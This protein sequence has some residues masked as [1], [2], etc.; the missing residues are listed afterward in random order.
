VPSPITDLTQKTEKAASVAAYFIPII[1]SRTKWWHW[2]IGFILIC[3]LSFGGMFSLILASQKLLPTNSVTIYLDLLL[4][5]LP[6]FISIPLIYKFWHRRPIKALMTSAKTFRW[7][8]M[9]RAGFVL[10]AFFSVAS[11]LESIILPHEY[12]GLKIQP[13]AKK[14][15]PLLLITLIFVPFQAASEE[16]L[17]RGYL[18]QALVKYLHS[19]WIV[20]ALTSAGFAAL[21]IANPEAQGQMW[22]YLASIFTFGM[23]MCV[24]LFFEGGI[25]SAIGAHI[26]N[27]IFVFGFLG[28]EDPH[29]PNTAWMTLGAPKIGWGDFAIDFIMIGLVTALIIWANR[30]SRV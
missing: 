30:R 6:I 8:N 12:Q 11:L 25:E 17:C 22:P 14:Y 9:F 19:P 26:A 20:F 29:L 24:L 13:D 18:N 5:F 2:L 28:Y 10:I 23:A 16:F 27:N 21:H 1:G 15:I 4:A 7:D 3:I